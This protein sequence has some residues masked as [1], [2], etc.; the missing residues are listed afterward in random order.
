MKKTLATITLFTMA[1]LSLSAVQARFGYTSVI[2]TSVQTSPYISN[3]IYIGERVDCGDCI[4][5]ITKD[6]LEEESGMDYGMSLGLLDNKTI[7]M[8]SYDFDL[9]LSM[10]IFTSEVMATDSHVDI[11][12]DNGSIGLYATARAEGFHTVDERNE[13]FTE[14]GGTAK[15][16]GLVNKHLSIEAEV[17]AYAYPV[18]IIDNIVENRDRESMFST[19]LYAELKYSSKY[20][21]AYIGGGLKSWQK[22]EDE[23]KEAIKSDITGLVG[24]FMPYQIR[25]TFSIGADFGTEDYRVFADYTYFC[26][27]PEKAWE[28]TYEFN[29]FTNSNRGILRIGVGVNL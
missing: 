20:F 9:S 7:G 25:N 14:V 24:G 16:H 1:I 13:F 3:G 22:L 18:F 17:G 5:K 2:N 10:N 4:C 8:F 26:D 6:G 11:G 19:S 21:N 12:I 27:H 15:V 29:G 28:M 23:A